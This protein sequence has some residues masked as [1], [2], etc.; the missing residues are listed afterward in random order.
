MIDVSNIIAQYQ[1][2]LDA[3]GA[4]IY[5]MQQWEDMIIFRWWLTLNETGDIKKL[6]LPDSRRLPAFCSLFTLPVI[7]IYTLDAQNE[8]DNAAWFNSVD[9]TSKHRAAYAAA[10]CALSCRGTRKQLSFT[11]CAYSLAFEVCDVLMGLTWQ[12]ELL[13][14]HTK[15][16]YT[17]IGCIP[18]MHD[19]PFSYLVHLKKQDYFNS[20]M[21]KLAQ[22][23]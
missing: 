7:L 16:G 11:D 13:D 17:I 21:H 19:E 8:I 23:S 14:I 2:K 1:P 9:N 3:L 18:D 22:R 6:I 4:R 5:S 12:Q 10:Y 15:M 20:R